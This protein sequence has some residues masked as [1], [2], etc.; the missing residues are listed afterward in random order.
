MLL[1]LEKNVLKYTPDMY[2]RVI[3][4]LADKGYAEDPVFW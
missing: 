2:V 4:A 3:R 1:N